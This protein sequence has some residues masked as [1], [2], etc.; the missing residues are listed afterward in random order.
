MYLFLNIILTSLLLIFIFSNMG[1]FSNLSNMETYRFIIL[2]LTAT[3]EVIWI[4]ITFYPGVAFFSRVFNCLFAI[5]WTP[6]I[7]D[8]YNEWRKIK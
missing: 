4:L 8:C 5:I 2:C 1:I 6:V 7:L 3:V